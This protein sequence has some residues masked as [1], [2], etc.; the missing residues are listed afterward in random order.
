M[1]NQ[2]PNPTDTVTHL[3]VK[4][5]AIITIEVSEYYLRRC[6]K[7]LIALGG[8]MG[9]EKFM[10]ALNKL[11]EDRPIETF[12]EGVLD[13]VLPLVDSIEKAAEAQGMVE[14]KT[15]SAAELRKGYDAI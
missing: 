11:K 13:V 6:Q 5:N 1:E 8:H 15:F 7:L 10:E 4:P 12:E 9:E 2:E 14:T 3:V